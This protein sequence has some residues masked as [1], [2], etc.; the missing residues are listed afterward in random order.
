MIHSDRNPLSRLADREPGPI[1]IFA[2]F[3]VY[4][5]VL[6]ALMGAVGFVADNVFYHI[7]A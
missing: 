7:A 4:L 1:N 6:T 5:T 2:G 3:A